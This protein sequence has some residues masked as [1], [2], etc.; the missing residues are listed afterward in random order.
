MLCITSP[1]PV[2]V[3]TRSYTIAPLLIVSIFR[4]T[5][6]VGAHSKLRN[7]FSRCGAARSNSTFSTSW[8]DLQGCLSYFTVCV[9]RIFRISCPPVAV[10]L[11]VTFSSSCVV[12]IHISLYLRLTLSY[13][14]STRS[15]SSPFATREYAALSYS[16]SE[17][18]IFCLPLRLLVVVDVNVE[19]KASNSVASVSVSRSLFGLA[20]SS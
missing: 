18:I 13:A 6:S 2:F 9:F 17:P 12:H 14:L 10:L 7:T 4:I 3:P 20:S 5:S 19:K 8:S 15:C 1:V 16:L 11:S